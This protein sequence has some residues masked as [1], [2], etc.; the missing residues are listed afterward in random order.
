MKTLKILEVLQAWKT[1]FSP[2]DE[3]MKVAEARALICNDCEHK[4]ELNNSLLTKFTEHDKLLN[5]FKCGACG[6]P[7][8]KKLFTYFTDACPLDKWEI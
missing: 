6:C 7:L 4:V 5:K 2:S 3:E 1:S 8:S